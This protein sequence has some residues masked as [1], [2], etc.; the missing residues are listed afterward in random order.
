MQ[1]EEK[2]LIR[3]FIFRS[4]WVGPP[5]R[6]RE[7]LNRRKQTEV[8]SWRNC[9]IESQAILRILKAPVSLTWYFRKLFV[10]WNSE[11][12]NH[13]SITCQLWQ[14][15]NKQ[16]QPVQGT[17]QILQEVL[18]SMMLISVIDALFHRKCFWLF[19]HCVNKNRVI[20][21]HFQICDHD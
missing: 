5:V 17:K 20:G 16:P 18:L 21:F 7:E 8:N 3:T 11:A 6:L 19:P 4:Q 9:R 13:S 1:N 15:V 10:K 2:E 12:S 14:N